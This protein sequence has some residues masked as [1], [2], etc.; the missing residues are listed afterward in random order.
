M[1]I[2][3]VS[4]NLSKLIDIKYD[5]LNYYLEEYMKSKDIQETLR[6]KDIIRRVDYSLDLDEEL[7]NS[8]K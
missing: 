6:I 3:L 5:I 7:R 1:K 2:N 8:N 4:M